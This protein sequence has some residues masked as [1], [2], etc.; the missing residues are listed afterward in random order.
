MTTIDTIITTFV[1]KFDLPI[2]YNSTEDFH[3]FLIDKLDEFNSFIIDSLND[4]PVED[5]GL[6]AIIKCQEII[7]LIIENIKKA[8]DEYYNGRPDLA[9]SIFENV[10][11]ELSSL[12]ALPERSFHREAF[13]RIRIGDNITTRKDIFHIPFS[14]RTLV[15][16]QRYS[17]A[18]YP[19]LYLA[20]SVYVA[21]EEFHRP[22][23]DTLNFAKLQFSDH[24][25]FI[26]FSPHDFQDS[27]NNSP[28]LHSFFQKM[29]LYPVLLVC[30]VKVAKPDNPFKPEY[31]FSQFSLRWC[32]EKDN[33]NGIMYGSTR[34]NSNS[35]G[36]FYNFAIPVSDYQINT[37]FCPE[38]TQKIKLTNPFTIQSID[39]ENYI[40][41]AN[42]DIIDIFSKE[43]HKIV[44][45]NQSIFARIEQY[46]QKSDLGRVSRA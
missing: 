46:L 8:F 19:C 13:Y 1:S 16:S 31:I 42:G 12:D 26:N 45:F 11:V 25:N 7:Q 27:L 33:Y 37:D 4:I 22:S 3:S 5:S 24:V 30:S 38:L 40:S 28:N 17:I 20:N 21:W 39:N 34:V 43:L 10:L 41:N 18:G 15:G 35:K 2:H 14:R 9:Y 29:L 36:K 32:K 23:L 6:Q 44:P